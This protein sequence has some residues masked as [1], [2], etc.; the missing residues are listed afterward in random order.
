MS[1][2][3]PD[4]KFKVKR[5]GLDPLTSATRKELLTPSLLPASKRAETGS[6]HRLDGIGKKEPSPFLCVDVDGMLGRKNG[7]YCATLAFWAGRT[8]CD[9]STARR[10]HC[11][12][13]ATR[14][15]SACRFKRQ[16]PKLLMLAPLDSELG[17]GDLFSFHED[18]FLRRLQNEP[19]WSKARPESLPQKC[20]SANTNGDSIDAFC[21]CS[22]RPRQLL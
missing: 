22:S 18:T 10:C 21:L 4:A 2:L 6:A 13:L 3:R 16:A 8:L 12:G 5:P 11:L 7:V 20:L 1:N 9:S 17:A 19:L 15:S 14:G